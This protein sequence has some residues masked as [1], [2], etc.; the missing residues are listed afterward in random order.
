MGVL[1]SKLELENIEPSP[2]RLNQNLH[3]YS[4]H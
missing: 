2:E 4:D 3:F 1:G